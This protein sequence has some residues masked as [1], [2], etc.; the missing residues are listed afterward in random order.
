MKLFVRLCI[1]RCASER[2]LLIAFGAILILSGCTKTVVTTAAEKGFQGHWEGEIQLDT[3]VEPFQIDLESEGSEIH[4]WISLR[5]WNRP[6]TAGLEVTAQGRTLEMVLPTKSHQSYRF[7]GVRSEEKIDGRCILKD[8]RA[9][10]F[11]M[12]HARLNAAHGPAYPQTPQPP[13]PYESEEV[14]F[15]NAG[16]NRTG[17]LTHPRGD[18]PYPAVFII[19]GGDG[20]DRNGTHYH[21]SDLF[22]DH[23]N[24]HQPILVLADALTRAGVVVLRADSRGFGGSAGKDEETTL[25]GHATD[26]AAAIRLLRSNPKVAQQKIGIIG[27]S[28]GGFAALTA[29]S[30]QPD[31]RFVILLSSPIRPWMDTSLDNWMASPAVT[32]YSID[33]Q[34]LIERL[35]NPLRRALVEQAQLP[36]GKELKEEQ[37]REIVSQEFIDEM[38]KSRVNV[39]IREGL[40]QLR[41]DTDRSFIRYD[42]VVIVPKITC[43]IFALFGEKDAILNT[44]READELLKLLPPSAKMDKSVIVIPNIDHTLRTTFDPQTRTYPPFG[45]TINKNVL[46]TVIAW[47]TQS[48]HRLKP[49]TP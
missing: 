41:R 26:V 35:R 38:T 22:S 44:R 14:S 39:A 46:Q 4:G 13:F 17:T 16:I 19:Q 27:D 32:K 33:E 20:S 29:A 37:I 43:K 45:E 18:G 9:V 8:G 30:Q 25:E 47:A 12:S 48:D 5:S 1:L 3:Y 28:R 10:P 23:G 40:K 15:S 2:F 24:E 7:L 11:W 31:I 34:K 6:G 21:G 42:P 49:S 36:E